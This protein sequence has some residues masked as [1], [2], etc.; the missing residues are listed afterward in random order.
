MAGRLLALSAR[1]MK[2]RTVPLGAAGAHG[3]TQDPIK[4]LIGNREVVG[5]GTNG[6]PNYI[7]RSDFPLPSIRWRET[8]ADVKALREKEKGDWRQMSIEEKKQLYRSSFRQTFAEFKAPT[9]EWKSIVG[10]TL[11][12]C[13][14]GLW[15]FVGMKLFVYNE[16]PSSFS[17]ENQ[18]AQMRR[19]LDLHVN[20]IEG[21]SS[22]WD[23][24]KNT[25]K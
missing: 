15:M 1:S 22:K 9:G 19:M 7:D 25:W 16:L 8:T 14:F 6:Q 23:Y 24:E 12:L 3:E 11:V 4:A 13:S 18:K 17:E 10:M 20:P 21:I 5:Y 2:V